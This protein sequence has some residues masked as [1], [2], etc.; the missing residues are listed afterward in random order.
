MIEAQSSNNPTNTKVPPTPTPHSSSSR[1]T[2]GIEEKLETHDQ[3]VE[4]D[5]ISPNK[6]GLTSKAW[7]HFRRQMIDEKWKAICNYCDK[8]LFGETKQ[9]SK[10]LHDHI[11]SC[12]LRTMM[13]LRQSI[14]KI[15]E[16]ST[17]SMGNTPKSVVVRNYSFN[18]YDARKELVRMFILHEYPIMMVEHINFKR[19]N[20]ALQPLFKIVSRN[21]IKSDIKELYQSEKSKQMKLLAKN[22][23]CIVVTTNT[24]NSG[25]QN[26]GYM[27][28]TT[29]Y[30]DDN[31]TL[32]NCILGLVL[33]N[34]IIL[35]VCFFSWICKCY[36]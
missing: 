36:D 1:E 24:W 5:R 13:G 3:P 6:R 28:V 11:R 19:Y 7:I 9:G 31:W 12:K 16:Q 10:H 4:V 32:Q 21:T 33:F 14:L 17:S 35:N 22:K 20:K 18:Q 25:N 23:S 29:H 15:M 8:K 2:R 26:T 30:I 27:H 34:N